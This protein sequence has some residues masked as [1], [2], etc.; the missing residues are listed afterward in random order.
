VRL[1]V[2]CATMADALLL[3][4]REPYLQHIDDAL[5]D[6]VLHRKDILEFPVIALGPQMGPR[7]SVNELHRNVH[8]LRCTLH[9]ALQQV[10]DSQFA[11][12]LFGAFRHTFIDKG[13]VT[14]DDEKTRHP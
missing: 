1:D 2:D 13:G 9:A 6:V 7:G 10:S 4:G 8:P 11:T 14:G 12:D 3:C 5:G